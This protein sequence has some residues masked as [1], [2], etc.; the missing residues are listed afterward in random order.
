M[1]CITKKKKTKIAFTESDVEYHWY[2][3]HEEQK[4]N[5][6]E[7]G[8]IHEQSPKL[9]NSFKKKKHKYNKLQKTP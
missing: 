3:L 5:S 8:T 4:K 6:S 7:D 2:V 9:W 1:C